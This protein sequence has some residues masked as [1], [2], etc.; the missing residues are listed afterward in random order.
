M[1]CGI[2]F[3][4]KNPSPIIFGEFSPLWICKHATA[5]EHNCIYAVCNGCF[6]MPA[7]RRMGTT[8]QRKCDSG[9]GCKH[10]FNDLKRFSS[11][12]HLKQIYKNSD[13]KV[14]RYCVKCKGRIV[15]V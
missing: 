4:V 13:A 1:N 11:V 6:D 14:P 12:N 7:R 15:F 5:M 10:D 2:T 3:A 8:F 9:D